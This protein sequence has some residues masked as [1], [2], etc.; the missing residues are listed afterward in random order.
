MKNVDGCRNEEMSK[1]EA[2]PVITLNKLLKETN[3]VVVVL[4]I[5]V[6]GGIN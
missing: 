6:N 3:N 1:C 2:Q 4:L 5:P